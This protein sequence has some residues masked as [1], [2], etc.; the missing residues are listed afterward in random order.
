MDGADVAVLV[1][2]GLAAHLVGEPLTAAVGRLLGGR[3]RLWG[4]MVGGRR[5]DAVAVAVA[6]A[7]RCSRAAVGEAVG[8]DG[9]GHGLD[10]G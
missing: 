5:L 9:G 7:V 8:G 2:H 1:A 6:V 3:G 4:I 10:A